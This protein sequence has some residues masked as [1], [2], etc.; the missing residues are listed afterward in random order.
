MADA[1]K[2]KQERVQKEK[3]D[4]I[5]KAKTAIKRQVN[6][7]KK[8]LKAQGVIVCREEK[9]RKKLIQSYLSQGESLPI[10]IEIPICDPEKE[11]TEA[12]QDAL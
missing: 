5:R 2:K 8:E 11:P 10:G 1:R 7:A 12:E 3:D 6:K 4:E 9:N